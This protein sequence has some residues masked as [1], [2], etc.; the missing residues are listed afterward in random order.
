VKPQRNK[1]D[2]EERAPN[3]ASSVHRQFVIA[4]GSTDKHCPN[5]QSKLR[6][7]A[8]QLRI[9]KPGP[10]T[11]VG[12]KPSSCSSAPNESTTQKRRHAPSHLAPAA[13]RPLIGRSWR[14]YLARAAG[15]IG[16]T[17]GF[18][19]RPGYCRITLLSRQKRRDLGIIAQYQ[20]KS[21]LTLLHI[22]RPRWRQW[23][24]RRAGHAP[25]QYQVS[26][27]ARAKRVD[28]LFVERPRCAYCAALL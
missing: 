21:E 19:V 6:L 28:R 9:R 27:C 23:L 2:G 17:L 11:R 12:P 22:E 13:G 26:K 16:L 20:F 3:F 10:C 15:N 24:T 5:T 25:G 7:T 1:R 8:I 18:A 4:S 14:P